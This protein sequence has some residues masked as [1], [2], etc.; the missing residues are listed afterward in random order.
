MCAC[1][2]VCVC[3]CALHSFRF[4]NNELYFIFPDLDSS[5]EHSASHKSTRATTQLL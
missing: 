4:H 2:C 3:V 1:V 5:T